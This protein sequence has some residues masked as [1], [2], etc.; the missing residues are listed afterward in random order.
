MPVFAYRGVNANGQAVSG[1]IDASER[2]AAIRALSAK[3][4]RATRIETQESV[5][6]SVASAT[7]SPSVT[8]HTKKASRSFFRKRPSKRALALS[9]LG[10]LLTLLEAGLPLGDALR[11]LSVRVSDPTLRQLSNDLWRKLSEGST[12]AHAMRDHPGLFNESVSHLVEAGEASG[13]LAPVLERIVESLDESIQL[14]K[15]IQSSLAYPAMI[16]T[17]AGGVIIFFLL[18]LLPKIRNMLSTLGGDLPL[19][20]KILIHGSDMLVRFGPFV[21]AGIAVLSVAI[22]QWRKTPAGRAAT[23]SWLLRIPVINNLFLYANIFQTSNLIATLLG[24]G[25][26]TTESLRLVERTIDNTVLRGKFNTARRQIQEGVSMATAIKRVDFM[27]DMAMDILT[28][29]ENT[30]NLVHSLRNINRIYREELTRS[31]TA[32]TNTVVTGALIF[33]FSM[34]TLIALSIVLGVLGVSQALVG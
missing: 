26:N 3:S 1:E 22:W 17:V 23:D 2:R 7:A 12:L 5:K 10:K 18:Y 33:A 15:Q 29:G 24:S 8:A 28:V 30:G 27:P 13:N 4:I 21:A 16:C 6:K 20:S 19:V 31:L 11:L 25:V 14:K 9:F 34:V 32:L